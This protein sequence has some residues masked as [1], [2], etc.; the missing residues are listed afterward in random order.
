MKIVVGFYI[1]GRKSLIV[2]TT[3]YHHLPTED[4]NTFDQNYE[5]GIIIFQNLLL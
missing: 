2:D 3:T 4:V 1:P 5:Y